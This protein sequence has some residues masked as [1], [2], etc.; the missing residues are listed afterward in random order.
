LWNQEDREVVENR[1]D[2]I[3]KNSRKKSC[4]LIDVIIPV[5]RNVM[6]K[7]TGKKLQYRGIFRDA[8]NMEHEMYDCTNNNWGA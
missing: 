2:I 6:Q 8:V 3:T 5:D 4:I 7:E 1:P